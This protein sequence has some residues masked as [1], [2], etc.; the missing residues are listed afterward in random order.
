MASINWMFLSGLRHISI[1]ADTH[2]YKLYFFDQTIHLSWNKILLEFVDKYLKG[3]S[4]KNPG[5]TIFEKVVQIFTTNYQVYLIIIASVF[6]IPL[7][8][9]IYKNSREPLISFILYSTL[10]YSFFS[11]TG[12]RQTIATSLVV[13]VGYDFIKN[14]KL[15]SFLAIVAVAFTIHKSIIAFIPFYFLANKRITK[16]YLIGS[17]ITFSLI[18]AFRV[19]FMSLITYILDYEE[20]N[21]QFEGAGTWTFTAMLLMIFGVTIW[22]YKEMIINNK[23][24]LHF[25][26]ALIIALMLIPLTYIDPSAMRSVQY[27]SIFL[28]LLV[29]ELINTFNKNERIIVYY[30]ALVTLI[31]LFIRNNPHYLFFWQ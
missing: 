2:V 16:G 3:G 14:R 24:S 29:P 6:T 17:L 22:K 8:K 28:M 30:V 9:W 13:L 1:G 19:Q 11:I 27:Y 15:W 5:Y 7:G 10:F 25:I 12:L 31:M 23:Q 4:G 26:N 21:V 18:F 20:Y